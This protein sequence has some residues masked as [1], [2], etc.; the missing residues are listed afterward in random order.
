MSKVRT[1]GKEYLLEAGL[2]KYSVA[3]NNCNMFAR[4]LMREIEGVVCAVELK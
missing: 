4:E 1:S 2:R 3:T